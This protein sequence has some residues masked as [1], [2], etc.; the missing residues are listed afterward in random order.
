MIEVRVWV[1]RSLHLAQGQRSEPK[2]EAVSK[3]TEGPKAPLCP[4]PVGK[5][6]PVLLLVL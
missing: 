2:G 1:R 3:E 5:Q 4:G 6:E